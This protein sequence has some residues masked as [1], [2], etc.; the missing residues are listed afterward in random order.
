MRDF[1]EVDS[2]FLPSP[3]ASFHSL[4]RNIRYVLAYVKKHN[5]DVIHITGDVYYL[6]YFLRKYKVVTTVHDL[7][8][9]TTAPQ[10]T[11][12]TYLQRCIWI[13]PLKYSSLVTFI[14][15]K[16]RQ[17]ALALEELKNT[18]VIPNAVYDNYQYAPKKLNDECP[19]ILHLGTKPNK[20]LVNTIK[21]L[22]GIECHLR[23]I[24]KIDSTI[25]G[26]LKNYNVNYSNVSNLSDDEILEEYKKCDIVSFPSLYEGFGMPI[27][28]GQAIGRPVVTSSLSPMKEIAGEAAVLVNPNDVSSIRDGFIKAS[29]NYDSLVS[30]GLENVKKYRIEA[31]ANKY[32]NSYNSLL[33]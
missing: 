3:Y 33:L 29:E 18:I 5:Y 24:G 30:Q 11:L 16:S 31:V 13:K 8:F 9:Y 22:S 23:I 17:E 21:A 4:Y 25:E 10:K 14:S 28:E 15:E 26:L 19:V 32:L 2:I 6:A 7:G 27:I 1:A 20:N 12:R